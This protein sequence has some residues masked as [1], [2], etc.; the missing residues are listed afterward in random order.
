ML[1]TFVCEKRGES[2]VEVLSDSITT[3]G[4]AV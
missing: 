4:G 3:N 2:R 1:G